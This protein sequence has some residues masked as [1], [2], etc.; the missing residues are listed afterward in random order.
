MSIRLRIR[1][2]LDN[3]DFSVREMWLKVGGDR[4]TVRYHLLRMV[5]SGELEVVTGGSDRKFMPLLFRKASEGGRHGCR[6]VD[7][8]DGV[9]HAKVS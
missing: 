5:Q 2:H 1:R 8:R 6:T 3:D 4:S 7:R 9:G